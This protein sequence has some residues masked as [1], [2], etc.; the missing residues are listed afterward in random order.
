MA[1]VSGNYSSIV[2]GVSQQAPADRLEGQHGEV[3]NMLSDPVRGLVR[4]NGMVLEDQVIDLMPT[5]ETSDATADS[6]S[7]RT[8]SYLADNHDIDLMY[9]SRAKVGTSANHLPGLVAF[10]KTPGVRAFV[11]VV[12]DAADTDLS[13][14][15]DGGISA[16]VNVGDYVLLAGANVEP[17]YTAVDKLNGQSYSNSAVAW[18]RGGVYSRQYVVYAQRASDSAVF[19][20]SYTTYAAAYPNNLDTSGLDYTAADYQ[21]NINDMTYA[22]NAAVNKWIADAAADIVPSNI[23]Q[24]LVDDLT[25][26]GFTGWTRNGSHIGST[27]CS[28]LMVSD[29]GDGSLMVALRNKTS[30]ADEVTDMHFPGKVVKVAPKAASDSSFYL[31]ADL[32]DGVASGTGLQ[33]VVWRETAGTL[34]TPTT[35][36]AFGLYHAGSFYV[37]SAPAK[38]EALLLAETGDTIDVP[39]YVPSVSGDTDSATPPYFFGKRITALA[40]F[41]DRLVVASDSVVNMSRPGDY[42][43]F[44]RTSVL[45]VADDD[46]IEVYALGS[47]GD[48]IRQAGVYDRSL[49]LGGD[50]FHYLMNGRQAHTPTTAAISVQFTIAGTSGARPQGTGQFMFWLKE[51][52]GLGSTRLLQ[53]KQ[54]VFQDNPQMDDVSRQLRDYVNGT[55]AEMVTLSSPDVIFV[56]T[57]H[58]LKSSTAFPRARPWGLYVYQFM[59]D[60]DGRRLADA[61]SAWEWSTSLGTPIGMSALPSADGIMLY[62][63]A[64]GLNEDGDRVR[65][66]LAQTASAR[67]DPTGLPYLDGMQP[68]AAAEAAGLFTPAAS[69]FVKDV[70]FTASGAKHSYIRLISTSDVARFGGLEHPHYAVGDGPPEAVDPFRW[71]GV[72]GNF[73]TFKTEYPGAFT[74]DVWTGVAFPAYVDITAPFVRDFKGKAKTWGRLILSRLRVTLLRTAGFEAQFID[75]V[76]TK[77]IAHFDGVFARLRYGMNLWVGRDAREVQVRLAAKNWLP[78]TINA[79]EWT[80]QWFEPHQK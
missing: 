14:F 48:V 46:P 36:F 79:L 77:T 15:L 13:P 24:K 60:Q 16:V 29:S 73:S 18:V 30:A 50:K 27:D 76:G 70:T 43:N 1:K 58:F 37:A 39:G 20:A 7:Y 54:G 25:A 31:R 57:E 55:P 62:T 56:R 32:K 12:S 28:Y 23:A 21:K 19:T 8:Y 45:T 2:R 59:D 5:S 42:L 9:R 66:I 22:Y 34:Q 41:Q 53:V 17:G 51:D 35:V 26:Q 64:W 10:D 38:L 44:Y 74:D 69:Q 4:R 80:G 11:P 3:L 71:A 6:F 78:L 40:L 72:A 47:E 65:G 61:W 33:P 63:L 52:T 75:H 49:I 67:P 68:A